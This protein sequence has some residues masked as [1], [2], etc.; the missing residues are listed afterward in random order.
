MDCPRLRTV[1]RTFARIGSDAAR[2]LPVRYPD[3][4]RT[5]PGQVAG[6]YVDNSADATPEILPDTARTLRGL[7]PYIHVRGWCLTKMTGFPIPESRHKSRSAERSKSRAPVL[8]T[9]H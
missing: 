3:A 2:P 9:T 1:C 8:M 4:A 7:R 6:N 5:L